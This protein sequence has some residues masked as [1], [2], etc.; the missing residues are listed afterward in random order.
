V[1]KRRVHTHWIDGRLVDA[2]PAPDSPWARVVAVLVLLLI[3]DLALG[4]IP[5][6]A[7]RE[8]AERGPATAAELRRTLAE[9]ASS[10]G[11]PLL[12][13]GDSVLAGDVLTSHRQHDWR[14][15]RV[16]EYMRRESGPHSEAELHQIALDGLLPVDAL[17]I[18]AELDRIDPAG[19]VELVLEINLRYFSAQYA[20]Q[21]D[22]TR[23]AIC[24]LAVA[25]LDEGGH[26]LL[27]AWQGIA[28]AA[29]GTRDWLHARVP[30]HRRRPRLDTAGSLDEVV[31]LAVRRK[32]DKTQARSE[33]EADAAE[34]EARARMREHYRSAA[35]RAQNEQLQAVGEILDRLAALGRPATLFLTPL[36]DGFAANAM[37]S[38]T[39][40]R[41]YSA[42][43][44]M[45][46][47]RGDPNIVLVDLDHPLFVDAHFIDHVHLWPEGA[48]L[49]A[50]NL[51][52]ELGLPLRVRPRE[53]TIVHPEGFDRS[54]VH[55]LAPPGYNEG[56]AWLAEFRE[57][58]GV[59][60][61]EAGSRIVIAD[62]QNH[63][64]R[65]LRNNLQ[66][67][68]TIA[69][70]PAKAGAVD[71][72]ARVDA[73]LHEPRDPALLGEAVWFIDGPD[74]ERVR[75]LEDD[76]VRSASWAGP[77]CASYRAMRAVEQ[78]DGGAIWLL[79]DDSRLLRLDPALAEARLMSEVALAPLQVFDVGGG[80]VFFADVEGRLWQRA[81][82]DDD[83]DGPT[84]P[85]LGD[86]ELIFRNSGEELL[87][88]G[89]RV[90]YPY[91]Y[92][93]LRLAKVLDLRWVERYGGLLIADEFP[94]HT[95]RERLA[96]EWTERVHLRYF[97]LEAERVLPWIKA[98]PHGDAHVMW[99]HDTQQLTSYWHLGSMALAQDD[100]SLIWV[101][102][103]RSR[104]LR[105]ADGL[106]GV[107]KT[108]NHH[109]KAVTV[110]ILM[111]IAGVSRKVEAQMRPD[112]YLDRRW[113]PIPRKG[114]YVAL[115][116]GSSLSSMSD[117]FS[118][119]SLGRRLE[120]ELQREL[121]YRDGLRLDLFQVSWAAASFGDNVNNFGNWM[122][123]SVPP[124]VVFIE[125]H[126][127]GSGYLRDTKTPA[128]ISRAF[129]KLQRYAERY[130]TLVVFYDLSSIEA[131]RREAMRST[132]KDV[133]D[134]LATA[135]RL[136]FVV[137]DPGDRLLP[138][139]L[140]HSPWGNQP[141][142]DNQHHGSTWAVDITAATLAA[143]VAPRLREHFADRVPARLRERPPAEFDAREG[144]PDPL[145]PAL[146][147]VEIDLTKLPEVPAAY[148]QTNYVNRELRVYVDLAGFGDQLESRSLNLLAVAVILDVLQDDVYAD[149]AE[150]IRLELVE[151][152]S[153]DEY[154]NGVV[155]SAEPVWQRQFDREQ[156]RNFLRKHAP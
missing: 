94:A 112:R 40:G 24:E 41:R 154:G 10:E 77:S 88:H 60:V 66:F 134:L 17:H 120:L 37:S 125:A 129:A 150:R 152:A 115:L 35:L 156:L 27:R 16:V 65:E 137:L 82:V 97:D 18:L 64:L 136:G 100:A 7:E 68:E 138:E 149:L 1:K 69:G 132:D 110:P 155:A 6:E 53:E 153:Y 21:R 28:E 104:V 72:R 9:A 67:V 22:C 143:M 13:V 119:Y 4:M 78:A 89:Y 142:G 63:V 46:N 20:E 140:M 109:T 118:N 127:F 121:G 116:L 81:I 43:A 145:R 34:A 99:N 36:E 90:F 148:V 128:E 52:H 83:G 84:P 56:G 122:A 106:L 146:D 147:E 144:T 105:V 11:R 74:R 30:V 42:L 55:H 31:G 2:R 54:L 57:P 32:A 123:T 101:E 135:A 91:H 95:D 87:P 102:R 15:H 96:R 98:L 47:D 29:A 107:A 25:A 58:E 12:L 86:W 114:P 117:R 44:G 108:G 151:F 124:D 3:F 26:P 92:D 62:T 51:L 75:V 133:R 111:T 14:E 38:D 49:L 113:E 130:D 70:R 61:D 5:A 141:F 19:R 80:R 131:N 126:D 33:P 76:W 73:R 48:K 50:I 45:V 79:C 139:L 23:P 59:A 85:E 8:A 39:L 71:G 103:S 93:D